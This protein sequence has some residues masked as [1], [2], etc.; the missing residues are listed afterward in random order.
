MMKLRQREN[1]F[2]VL[3]PELHFQVLSLLYL[4]KKRSNYISHHWKKVIHLNFAARLAYI[5]IKAIINK[6]L[7][8]INQLTVR[9]LGNNKRPKTIII[10]CHFL[11]NHL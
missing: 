2:Q 5:R 4:H 11:C 10:S 6:L 8:L 3:P 1:K 7:Q 9:E